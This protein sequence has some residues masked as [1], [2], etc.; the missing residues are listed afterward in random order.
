[1]EIYHKQGQHTKFTSV[2][3]DDTQDAQKV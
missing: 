2:R 3:I 1:M